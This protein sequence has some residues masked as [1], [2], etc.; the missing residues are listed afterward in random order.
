MKRIQRK[1]TKGY[2]NPEGTRYVGRGTKYG[3]PFRLSKDG[4]IEFFN[5]ITNEWEQWSLSGGFEINDIIGM[6]VMWI[7]N[8]LHPYKGVI[9]KPPTID[10]LKELKNYKYL[11]CYCPLSEPCHVDILIKLINNL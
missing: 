2:R 7:T 8:E 9:V 1:R 5:V 11:S 3:N 10:D 6:Y 4:Y